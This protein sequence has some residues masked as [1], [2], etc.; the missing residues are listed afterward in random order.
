[1]AFEQTCKEEQKQQ[2]FILMY[3]EVKEEKLLILD[4]ASFIKK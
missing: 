2:I 1:V 4:G 3:S